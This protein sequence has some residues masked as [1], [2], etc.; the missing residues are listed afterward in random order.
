MRNREG[1][2]ELGRVVVGSSTACTLPHGVE[3]SFFMLR[4]TFLQYHS[5]LSSSAR[6]DRQQGLR[7]GRVKYIHLSGHPALPPDL[8]LRYS[9]SSQ[10]A[11]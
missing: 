9:S 1:S 4:A 10:E 3:S 8:P 6:E 7:N 5:H 11:S 2:A